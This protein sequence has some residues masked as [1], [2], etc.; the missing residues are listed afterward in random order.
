VN[1]EGPG[2]SAPGLFYSGQ[3]IPTEIAERVRNNPFDRHIKEQRE[4]S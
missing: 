1:I 4:S 3:M 2:A